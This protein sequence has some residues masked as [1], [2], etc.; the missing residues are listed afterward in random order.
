MSCSHSGDQHL[1]TTTLNTCGHV[2]HLLQHFLH[3]Y[4]SI[5]DMTTH[6]GFISDKVDRLTPK[7]ISYNHP[8]DI[9]SISVCMILAML[10]LLD[11]FP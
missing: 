8:R 1:S 4:L 2:F 10:S 3:G 5:Y 9:K 7:K 11:L 6:S